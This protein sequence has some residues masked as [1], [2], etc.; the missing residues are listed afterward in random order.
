MQNGILFSSDGSFRFD[1]IMVHLDMGIEGVISSA[2]NST[3][4]T[5]VFIEILI[6]EG[7]KFLLGDG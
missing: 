2:F 5:V 1:A 3:A 6:I 7:V 4:S